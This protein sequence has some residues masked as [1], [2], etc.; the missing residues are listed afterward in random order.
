MGFMSVLGM[1]QKLTAER[2]APGDAVVD[3]TCGG[4]VDTRFLAELVGPRGI[5]YAFD[6]QPEALER[7]R[8]RLAPLGAGGRLPE[9][10]LVLGSHSLMA[11]RID[12]ALHGRLSAIM[13]NLGYLPGADTDKS[14]ITRTETTI[15]ALTAALALL[16]PGGIVTAA[17]YPGHPGGGAEAAAV[18]AWAGA[19]PWS[20]GQ[21]VLYRMAQKP[22]AP[23]LVAV[24][25]KGAARG[26][27]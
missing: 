15:P 22:E 27:G 18:E 2:V 24:E 23:Y 6:V 10:R 14:V 9:L 12:R 21:A 1:A 19:L 11:G 8:E 26:Q 20:D 13:F 4:G 3:A 7:T 25:K 17:L 5:V 16:R